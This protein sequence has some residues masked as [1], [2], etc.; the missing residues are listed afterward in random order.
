MSQLAQRAIDGRELGELGLSIATDLA[1]AG[2]FG[3]HPD[4][5]LPKAPIDNFKMLLINIRTLARNFLGSIDRE[6]KLLITPEQ[7]NTALLYEMHAIRELVDAHSKGKVNVGFYL[8]HYE[9]FDKLFPHAMLKQSVTQIQIVNEGMENATV[10]ALLKELELKKELPFVVVKQF[11]DKQQNDVTLLMTHIPVD[12][13]AKNSFLQLALLESHTGRVK[14]HLEWN[15]RLTNGKTLT[16]IP[17]NRFT[18]QVFGDNGVQF[19]PLPRKLKQAVLDIATERKW[20]T[21]TT[22]DR[23]RYCVE[24]IKDI[25]VKSQLLKLF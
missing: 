1:I 20:T 25:E 23:V 6:Y 21:I 14:N 11:L 8:S 17:F 15:T 9:G 5:P 2:A 12:L 3:K 13:L 16:N 4:R 19:S 18:L 10:K 22:P 24:Q 7:S